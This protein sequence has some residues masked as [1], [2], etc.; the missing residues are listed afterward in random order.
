MESP[1]KT[2]VY[3]ESPRRPIMRNG[4]EIPSLET[5]ADD[6]MGGLK[7]PSPR[8]PIRTDADVSPLQLTK[9][10]KSKQKEQKLQ[11]EKGEVGN[12]G[13]SDAQPVKES[14]QSDKVSL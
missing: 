13:P 11:E 6:D 8:V 12:E 2:P 4:V 1:R 3:N 5:G 9:K 10:D 14:D 7:S